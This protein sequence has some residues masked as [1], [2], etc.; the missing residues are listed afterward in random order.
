MGNVIID[1]DI[2]ATYRAFAQLAG[3]LEEKATNLFGEKDFYHQ[4]EIGKIDNASFRNLMRGEFGSELTDAEIDLAWCGLLLDMPKER[5]DRILE[6]TKSYRVFLLSNTNAIHIDEVTKRAALHGHD[7]MKLFEIPFLSYEMGFMKPDPEF[8]REV[9]RRGN[10][11]EE[12]TLFID[13]NYDNIQSAESVGIS[14]IW[15]NP[16]GSLLEKIKEY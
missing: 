3:F 5:L 11:K 10:M 1:I 4:V 14:T 16:L 8:Y 2:P 12:E 9:L 15:L 7:F 6:L 13:D